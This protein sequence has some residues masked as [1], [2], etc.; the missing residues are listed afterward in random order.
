ML[1]QKMIRDIKNNLSQFI[2]IFLMVTIGV[3]AYS[4]IKAYMDGMT[5]TA[6]VFYEENNLQDMNAY[7]LNFTENDLEKIKSIKNVKNAER[8]SSI[9]ATTDND[10]TLLLN[11]IETNE[12][13]KFYVIDGEGFSNKDGIWLDN[14]Y[15]IENNIKVGD[16]IKVN[17]ETK[18]VLGLINVPDHLYDT[19]DESELFPNRKT[20]GFAYVNKMD[21]VSYNYIMVDLEDTTKYNETK[22]EIEESL[23]NVLAVID[24]KDTASYKTYQGEIDEGKTYVGVFSGLFLLIALLSTLTTM[25]RVVQN[26]RTQIG[27]LKALGFS[28]KQILM[29]YIGYGFYISLLGAIAG[30]ILGYFFIGNVFINLEMSFFEVPNGKPLMNSVSYLVAALTILAII[31]VTII[32]VKNILKETPA[33]CLQKKAPTQKSKNIKIK[34]DKISFNTRWNLRDVLRN[35]TRTILGIIGITCS[36]MLIVCALGMLN[37][38]NYFIDLQFNKL[39]N[40]DYKLS[41]KNNLTEEELNNLKNKYGTATSKTYGI[42]IKGLDDNN[43]FVTDASDKV[44]FVDKK[45]KYITLTNNEGVYIT[46]KLGINENLKVG[47]IITW[48]LYGTDKYYTSTIVG[49]NKDPQNQNVT[50][51]REYLES[52][53]IDYTP[54]T[55]YTDKTPEDDKNIELSASVEELKKG[56]D[57][58]LNTM[59]TMLVLIIGIAIILGTIIIYNI[60]ILSLTEK[61]YQFAT[62]KVLGFKDKQI[63]KIFIKQ[64][65]WIAIIST[66]LGL[67]LGYALTSYLFKV[68]IEKHYDFGAHIN[69]I[70]YIIAAIG[71]YLIT[72]IV[73][74]ILSKKIEKID[75]VTSLKG[76]E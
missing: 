17:D 49:M 65:S 56:M 39:F 66:I 61:T 71:T 6:K 52:I 26:Q 31:I 37:S 35:K 33:S 51:T 69:I 72:Y 25:T 48:R 44:R 13:S 28:N 67:P 62:L 60:G 1:K 23:S 42:E 32:S 58:M 4:G 12:I 29:H 53:G 34:N 70:S 64:N 7:G 76:N 57:N 41:L 75:M 43:L 24:I 18:K 74:N 45:D 5:E 59:K 19:K 11:I 16:I 22:E 27:T 73:S 36:A 68:A 14:F 54:D 10:N 8:K 47:D 3:M 9:T 30:L 63:R 38:M 20:F 21:N 50:V 46:S 15:A 55:I 2:T 40:F